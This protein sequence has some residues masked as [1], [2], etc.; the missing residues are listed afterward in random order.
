[1]F[2]I[3]HPRHAIAGILADDPA[4]FFEQA[5]LIGGAQKGLVAIADRSQFAIQTTQRLLGALA[6]GDV[7]RQRQVDPTTAVP[8]R[9][10]THLNRECCPILSPMTCLK[11]TDPS[12][13]DSLTDALQQCGI[14]IRVEVMGRHPDQFL[15]S[16]AEALAGLPIHVKNSSL[17][18]LVEHKEG[19]ARVVYKSPEAGLTLAKLLLGALALGD[20]VAGH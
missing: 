9:A 12:V 15:T 17:L 13:L 16:V 4:D 11:G 2:G 19:I 3:A 8:Q 7:P 1:M 10:D 20:V 6:L 5:L 18:L 14:H